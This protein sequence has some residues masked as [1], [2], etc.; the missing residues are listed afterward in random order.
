MMYYISASKLAE[1]MKEANLQPEN[2]RFYTKESMAEVKKF[3]AGGPTRKVNLLND[4]CNALNMLPE[5]FCKFKVEP[6][7]ESDNLTTIQRLTDPSTP[8]DPDESHY[9]EWGKDPLVF[10]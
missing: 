1:C 9:Q 2:L 3:L 10:P 5:R 4:I 7:D 6:G 8:V